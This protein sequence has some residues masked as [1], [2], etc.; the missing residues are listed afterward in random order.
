MESFFFSFS[1]FGFRD[2]DN[3]IKSPPQEDTERQLQLFPAA[4]PHRPGQLE[5]RSKP[6]QQHLACALCSPIMVTKAP[7]AKRSRTSTRRALNPPMGQNATS[8][9]ALAG[10]EG[11]SGGS[12]EGTR[13]GLGAQG[14]AGL[15]GVYFI[16]IFSKKKKL[17]WQLV[18]QWSCWEPGC[19]GNLP[20][21]I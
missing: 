9:S 3:Q 21:V 10:S 20:L 12:S 1:L 4:T 13:A 2:Q 19:E 15:F 17:L 16:I 18:P 11:G 6:E 5:G 8:S 7:G 14:C